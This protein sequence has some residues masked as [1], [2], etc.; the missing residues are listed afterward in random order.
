MS[1][2]TIIESGSLMV[3]ACF[4]ISKTFCLIR[5]NREY[6]NHQDYDGLTGTALC[7]AYQTRKY[8]DGLIP[9][10]DFHV[11]LILVQLLFF[12]QIG[13]SEIAERMGGFSWCDYSSGGTFNAFLS[14]CLRLQL[15]NPSIPSQFITPRTHS[16]YHTIFSPVKWWNCWKYFLPSSWLVVQL[17]NSRLPGPRLLSGG[18]RDCFSFLWSFSV[19]L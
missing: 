16:P 10:A 6:W 17:R 5:N 11:P 2:T 3:S 8:V 14:S 18:V 7:R 19:L 12:I 13:W 4:T 9:C 1:S 15:F